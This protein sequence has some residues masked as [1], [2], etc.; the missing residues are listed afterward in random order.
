MPR[1]ITTHT[2]L[3][4]ALTLSTSP[5]ADQR[6]EPVITATSV[7]ADRTTV[8]IDGE[9]F[10]AQPRV[11]VDGTLLTGV[12]V[13]AAGTHVVATLPVL[14]PATYLL[15]LATKDRPSPVDGVDHVATFALVVGGKDGPGETGPPGPPG[16]TGPAGSVGPAGLIGPAGPIGL[17]G[18]IGPAGA[19]GPTGPIGP[20]GPAGSAGAPGVIGSFDALAGLSCVRDGAK[21]QIL[22]VYASNGDATL[23]C[24]L[25]APPPPPPTA[26]INAFDFGFENPATHANSVTITA[27]E[28]VVFAYPTGGNSHNV[29]FTEALPTSCMQTAGANSGPVPPLPAAPSSPG[30]TGTCRFDTP[31]TYVFVCTAHGFETGTVIVQPK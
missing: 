31:G 23:R 14:Q 5:L 21:G 16:P 29:D 22:L 19:I 24:A 8:F 3:L 6:R 9:N 13:D 2:I 10:G 28:S 1:L 17:A 30:W 25:P 18:P 7:S 20:I 4:L 12:T 15:Q 27:G 11:S 26:T